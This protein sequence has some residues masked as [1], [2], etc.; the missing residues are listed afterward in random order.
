MLSLI[1]YTTPRLKIQ[2]EGIVHIYNAGTSVTQAEANCVIGSHGTA[3]STIINHFNPH[4]GFEGFSKI[5]ALMPW[6]VKITFEHQNFIKME[7]IDV[8]KDN[9]ITPINLEKSELANK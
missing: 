5:K 4:F 8:F 3:L 7:S 6:I 9:E 2:Q 1:S